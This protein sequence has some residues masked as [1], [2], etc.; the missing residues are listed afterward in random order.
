MGLDPSCDI[1]VRQVTEWP[2]LTY[3]HLKGPGADPFAGLNTRIQVLNISQ[4]P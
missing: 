2:R 4:R 1:D 3:A